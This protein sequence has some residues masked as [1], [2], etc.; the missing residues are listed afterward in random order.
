MYKLLIALQIILSII[1]MASIFMQPSK[2]DGFMNFVSP[3]TDTYFSKNK[4]RTSESVL[5]NITIGS[6]ILIAIVT[7]AINLLV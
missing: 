1:V 6:S 3:N 2:A 4:V 7:I 5:H